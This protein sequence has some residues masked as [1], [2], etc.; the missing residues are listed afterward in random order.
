MPLQIAS[1]QFGTKWYPMGKTSTSSRLNIPGKIGWATMEAPGFI[2]LLYIMFTL[3]QKNGI[4]R[5][6]GANWLMA[7]LYVGFDLELVGGEYCAYYLRRQSITSTAPSYLHFFSIP[8]CPQST[9]SSGLMR[10][11]SNCAMLLALAAG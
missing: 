9:S 11:Y 10:F 2:S 5:L 3:P 7:T 4:E 8:A 6:P 1:F